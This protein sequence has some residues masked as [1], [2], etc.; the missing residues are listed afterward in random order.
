MKKSMYAPIVLASLLVLSA[1]GGE[2]SAG[3][4]GGDVTL[5]MLVW[6]NGPA[7]LKGEREI[8]DV[9][10]ERNPGIKVELSHVPWDNYIE[11]LTTMSA[12]G[13]QPDV[14]WMIDTAL[15]DYVNQGMLMELDEFIEESGIKEDEYLPGAWDIGSWEGGRYA[16]PRD[17]TSH[18]IVYNKDMFDETGHPYPEA[19]WTWDD[20]LEAAKATTIEEDGK[21]VQF[22]IAG[23]MWEEMIVQNGGASFNMDGSKVEL[24]SPETIEAI[25]FMHDL[26]Y[27]HRVAPLATESEG[28]GDLFLA[29]RAAM[30]YAGPWHWRQYAEDGEFEWDIVEVPAGKAGN[31]SQLL[32]LPIGIGSQTD[33]PEEAWKLLEFLTHGEGQS[34]QANI[35][36][37]NPSVIRESHTFAEGQWVPENVEA[38]QTIMEE[39]TVVQSMFPDKLEAVSNIQ[40]VID[41]IMDETRDMDAEEALGELADRLR[42]EFEMD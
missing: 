22:G 14:F 40:P 41:Q 23:L 7:E 5:R 35:V 10:E 6:G 3:G 8:L 30:A 19:G 16:M 4:G 34:I 12:G 15:I 25:E 29:N 13:N 1:C 28:L 17:L 18:H 11:R 37:A 24:D 39:N 26:V 2:E 9:F 21:I 20:F 32:G 38:F 31:K 27:V 33:H 42:T 36:G